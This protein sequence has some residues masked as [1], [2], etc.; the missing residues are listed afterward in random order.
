MQPDQQLKWPTVFTD[1]LGLIQVTDDVE[2]QKLYMRFIIKTLQI[3]DEEV[4]ERAQEKS[5]VELNL[6]TQIKNFVRQGQISP[7]VE[8]LK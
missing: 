5:V 6:S 2:V 3:F 8:V 7:I 4:V 1:L